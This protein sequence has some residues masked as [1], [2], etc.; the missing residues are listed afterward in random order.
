VS[1]G[2]AALCSVFPP[3]LVY[4]VILLMLSYYYPLVFIIEHF[5][6]MVPLFTTNIIVAVSKITQKYSLLNIRRFMKN[7][8]FTIDNIFNPNIDVRIKIMANLDKLR[9]LCE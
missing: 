7:N 8:R 4:F 9:V 1:C 6:L 5:L 3:L 2:W